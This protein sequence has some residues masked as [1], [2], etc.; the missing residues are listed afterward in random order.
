[1]SESK[2]GGRQMT[3]LDNEFF[4]GKR[5]WSKIKDKVLGGYMPAYLRKVTKLERPILLID[6]YAG[7]GVFDDGFPG[8]PLIM[9]KAAEQH[10]KNQYRALFVNHNEEHHEKLTA[11]LKKQGWYPRANPILGDSRSTTIRNVH[12]RQLEIPITFL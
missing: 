11:I 8:S 9:C 1:M 3:D 6:G 5:P 7:P 12:Q 4:Q 2:N 10:S